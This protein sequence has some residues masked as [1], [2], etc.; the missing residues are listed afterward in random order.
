[1]Q[2]PFLPLA[3]TDARPDLQGTTP[4]PQ[5]TAE[6]RANRIALRSRDIK[7]TK[8]GPSYKYYVSHMPEKNRVL[9]PRINAN[10]TGVRSWKGLLRAWRMRLHIYR[11]F[12]EEEE[13]AR[14]SVP[15]PDSEQLPSPP[16]PPSWAEVVRSAPVLA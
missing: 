5:L 2:L 7:E 6:E 10:T 8:G 4:L 14:A 1:M 3:V 11:A 15:D 9:T 13:A 16:P 12:H